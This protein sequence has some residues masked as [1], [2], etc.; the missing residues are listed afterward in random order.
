[1]PVE[2]VAP[3][4][5]LSQGD[6]FAQVPLVY[7]RSLAYMVKVDNNRFELRKKPPGTL[8]IRND[9]Q[10]NVREASSDADSEDP[11]GNAIGFRRFAVVLSHD[12][13]IDKMVERA[14]VLV[15]LVRE[16]SVAHE[17][18]RPRIRDYSEKRA[19]YLPSGRYLET[20]SFIDL[21]VITT[22][23]GQ[24]LEKLERIASMNEDGCM[25]MRAQLFRFFTRRK[26][27]SEWASWPQEAEGAA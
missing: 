23:R 26:L 17:D 13:E 9:H 24:E 5:K 18:D 1:L 12:C 2:F 14:T 19:F 15:A 22:I 8:E 27:P 7:V 11:F 6:L 3:V 4:E 21:R 25:A 10:A 16:L 20:E